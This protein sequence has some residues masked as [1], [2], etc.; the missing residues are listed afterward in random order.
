MSDE[1]IEAAKHV[2]GGAAGGATLGAFGLWLAQRLFSK[3]AAVEEKE[4]A[5][6]EAK[7]A[8]LE[9]EKEAGR[10]RQA[11]EDRAEVESLRVLMERVA[12]DVRSLLDHRVDLLARVE[13][14]EKRCENCPGRSA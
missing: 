6:L 3:F 9:A 8:K 1:M 7:V 10:E 14:I 13:K 4:K 5:E 12:L 2:G 11:Q